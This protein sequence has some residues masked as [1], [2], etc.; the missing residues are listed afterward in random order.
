MTTPH[1]SPYR[2]PSYYRHVWKNVLLLLLSLAT[3]PFSTIVL[4]AAFVY[5]RFQPAPRPLPGHYNGDPTRKTILVTGVSMTKGLVI[6][7][8]LAQHTPHR[9]IAADTSS[10]SPGRFSRSVSQFFHL[11]PPD[12]KDAEPYIDSLLQVITSESV[13]LWI[14]CSSVV[15]AVEDGAVVRLA[16][17]ARG[18]ANFQ[19]IQF[20]EDVVA[21]FHEKDR[22]IDHV[23][24]LGLQV[25][26]SHRCTSTAQVLDVLLNKKYPND[27]K[28]WIMKPIGVDDR[29]RNNMMTLLPFSSAQNTRQYIH[30][31]AVSPSNPFQ[32]Q[33]Y[34]SGAEYCTHALVIH[35]T[36][37]AF[38]ACPS[39]EL[40]M[41]Y[42]A[43]PASSTLSR[44]MLQFTQRIAEAGGLSFSG[45]LSFD[46]L[47]VE[48]EKDMQLYPIECNPRAHTAVVLF[49][50][51]RQLAS[52]YLTAFTP[53]TS[54]ASSDIV[55]PQTPTAAF[56]WFGHDVVALGVLPLLDWLYGLATIDEVGDA[57]AEFVQHVL[58]WRDG[59]FAWWDPLPFWVLYHVYWPAVF[60]ASVVWGKRWSRINVSTTKVFES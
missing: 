11:T 25:P 8:L 33:E 15:A 17:E 44:K 4:G 26:E 32:L 47:V 2:T 34:I 23:R 3:A 53:P 60:L 9:I 57:W 41:H 40:L 1:P 5:S 19:A 56:Y 59:T 31:L 49:N 45:H 28:R 51:T 29:A 6:S 16:E 24:S 7:R 37:A 20:R 35:G 36:V 43:L 52:A 10:L 38:T 27:P 13:D 48:D 46:F 14:S 22:F 21:K 39:A 54:L 55:S 18:S 58:Y 12:G 30:G 42:E 50:D